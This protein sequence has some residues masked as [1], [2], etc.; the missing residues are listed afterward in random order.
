MQKVTRQKGTHSAVNRE[1]A[2]HLG[3][4]HFSVAPFL[5]IERKR[6]ICTLYA[7]DKCANDVEN[8]EPMSM[9]APIDLISAIQILISVTV[10]TNCISYVL[11]WKRNKKDCPMSYRDIFTWLSILISIIWSSLP[12]S[13]FSFL[14]FFFTMCTIFYSTRPVIITCLLACK[15]IYFEDNLHL[16]LSLSLQK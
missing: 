7:F 15:L 13:S 3:E 10:R 11:Q 8:V 4:R 9:P 16:S 5:R 6:R 2:K 14:A 12:I 1:T